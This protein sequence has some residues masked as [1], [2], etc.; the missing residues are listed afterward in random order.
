MT[1]TIKHKPERR[2]THQFSSDWLRM[3]GQTLA[4]AAQMAWQ[5]PDEIDAN[6][7]LF[8][9][10]TGRPAFDQPSW[11]RSL[12][13]SGA[14]LLGL[15]SEQSMKALKIASTKD[16]SCLRTHDLARLW[17]DLIPEIQ[18][19]IDIEL[20]NVRARASSTTL[21]SGTLAAQDI[22][23]IHPNVF[24][25]A[26][27]HSELKIGEPYFELTHNIELWQLALSSYLCAHRLIT[28]TSDGSL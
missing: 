1:R 23:Q 10:I 7:S 22:V 28:R 19:G 3:A 21:G 16:G 13:W 11:R 26:R 5:S 2:L 9:K 8:E 25:S 6:R 18:Q 15:T 14:V 20:I 12:T 4:G 24:E 17:S 27:Y